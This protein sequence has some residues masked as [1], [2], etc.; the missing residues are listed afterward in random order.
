MIGSRVTQPSATAARPVALPADG[1]TSDLGPLP[2]LDFES[3]LHKMSRLVTRKADPPV[4]P[5]AVQAPGNRLNQPPR[6]SSSFA[7]IRVRGRRRGTG[8]IF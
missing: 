8:R 3:F 1:D 5:W 2:L 6:C 7:G 4:H